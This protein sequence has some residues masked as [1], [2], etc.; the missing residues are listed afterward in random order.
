MSCASEI[1]NDT[2]STLI[3]D[4]S[5]TSI[6]YQPERYRLVKDNYNPSKPLNNLREHNGELPYSE[7][8]MWQKQTY[9]N[10]NTRVHFNHNNT[11]KIKIGD[12]IKQVDSCFKENNIFV[13]SAFIV[14]HEYII[15]SYEKYL[16][17]NPNESLSNYQV[18]RYSVTTPDLFMCFD[19]N[20][21]LFIIVYAF[22]TYNEDTTVNVAKSYYTVNNDYLKCKDLFETYGQ[23]DYYYICQAESDI[24]FEYEFPSYH[25]IYATSGVV[26]NIYESNITLVYIAKNR[27]ILDASENFVPIERFKYSSD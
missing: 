16:A 18:A 13:N 23:P 20:G 4:F 7:L 1:H 15:N 25:V 14:D 17:N 8:Y 19:E 9:N 10:S 27:I 2:S 12:T 5:Y 21:V 11:G 6:L 24:L 3:S 26:E 22:M